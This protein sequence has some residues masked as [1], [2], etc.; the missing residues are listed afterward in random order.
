MISTGHPSVPVTALPISQSLAM[1]A[2]PKAGHHMYSAHAHHLMPLTSLPPSHVLPP[3]SSLSHHPANA[4][5]LNPMVQRLMSNPGIHSVES[6]EVEQ[7]R[8]TSPPDM[9]MTPNT[10]NLTDL[11]SQLREKLHIGSSGNMFGPVK[12]QPKHQQAETSV[13]K[14]QLS[15]QPPNHLSGASNLPTFLSHQGFSSGRP[16]ESVSSRFNGHNGVVTVSPPQA[17]TTSLMQPK[18]LV[19]AMTFLL[20]ND[21]DFVQKLHQAYVMSI[22]RKF[23][24]I[25]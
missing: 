10:K 5:N 2:V 9:S 25:K 12:E 3:N 20:A 23:L 17:P 16:T 13:S 11:E 18:E 15:R 6:V 8:S 21:P 7:R 1:E 14:S 22:N 4:T 24:I 19:E